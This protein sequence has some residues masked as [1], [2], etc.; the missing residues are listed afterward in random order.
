MTDLRCHSQESN[1]AMSK[2]NLAGR[3]NA[4]AGSASPA[5]SEDIVSKPQIKSVLISLLCSDGMQ[6]GSNPATMN[7]NASPVSHHTTF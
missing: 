5:P 4:V 2:L 1:I 6:M 7:L 3:I